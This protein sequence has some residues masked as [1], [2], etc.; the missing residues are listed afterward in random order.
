MESEASLEECPFV[1]CFSFAAL[2]SVAIPVFLTP[3][4]SRTTPPICENA[5]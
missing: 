4:S 1:L 2:F 5:R 3:H